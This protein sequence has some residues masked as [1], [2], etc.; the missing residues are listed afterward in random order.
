MSNQDMHYIGLGTVY[1][2]EV[3]GTNGPRP[4]GNVTECAL[5]P[6]TDKKE[7]RDGRT[8]GTANSVERVTGVDVEMTLNELSAE[9]LSLALYGTKTA[10]T[11]GAVTDEVHTV[12]TPGDFVLLDKLLDTSATVTVKDEANVSLV[13]DTDYAVVD[14]GIIILAGGSVLAGDD[15]KVSYASLAGNVIEALTRAGRE[16]RLVLVG[17]NEA[18]SGAPCVIELFRFKPGVT[19]SLDAL[20]DD[21]ASLPI[22]GSSLADPTKTGVGTSRFFKVKLA[23]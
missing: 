18:R 14:G 21:Y 10:L 6:Q 4:V 13:K 23:A 19:E 11:G 9:N 17:L 22:K 5:K 15:V 7:Q 1:L 8:G 12:K 16:Y 20:G 2:E 3:G